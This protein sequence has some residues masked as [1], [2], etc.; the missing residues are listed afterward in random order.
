MDNEE[1]LDSS[2]I[3]S[4]GH[5]HK[6]SLVGDHAPVPAVCHYDIFKDGKT[7]SFFRIVIASVYL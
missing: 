3:H 7:G 1:G 4:N 5:V 2:R 6:L